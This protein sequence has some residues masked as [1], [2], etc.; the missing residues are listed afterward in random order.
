MLHVSPSAPDCELLVHFDNIA[1]HI[2][3][4]T[5]K[6]SNKVQGQQLRWISFIPIINTIMKCWVI[7][8]FVLF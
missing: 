1:S 3:Y 8:N 6:S 2:D 7:F 4:L 5:E